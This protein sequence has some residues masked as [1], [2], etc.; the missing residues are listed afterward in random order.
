MIVVDPKVAF[1]GS[2]TVKDGDTITA[3]KEAYG[4]A[5]KNCNT[6][7]RD[8]VLIEVIVRVAPKELSF[9]DT[10]LDGGQCDMDPGCE[11]CQ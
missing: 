7:K 1:S 10:P 6:F 11:A 9:D 2:A 4:I 5:A 8:A 3:V